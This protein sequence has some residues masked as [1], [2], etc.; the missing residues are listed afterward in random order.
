MARFPALPVRVVTF[1]TQDNLLITGAY[2]P[3]PWPGKAPMA[4]L[5][6]M[7][8]SD[9]HAFDPLV[10]VLHGAGFAVLAIDLRG[11]GESVGPAA[12]RLA[13]RVAERD[14]KLFAEMDRD[15]EAAYAW[16][17]AQPEADPARF[18]LV[19]AS[20][21]CS[22]ALEYAARDRS[23]DA[24]V[25]LT[26]G[27]GY[28]GLDAIAAA[29]KY[30]RRPVLLIASEQEQAACDEL[31]GLLPGATVHVVG[32]AGSDPTSLH[33][34]RMFGRVVGIEAAI[35]AFL[36]TTAGEPAA[37][38]VKASIQGEVYHAADAGSARQINP[39]NLRWFSSA[40]EAQA[41]GLRPPK[42][43][44]SARGQPRSRPASGESFPGH[45]SLP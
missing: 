28:L 23:V 33:G 10:P 6:H 8:G 37:N 30:G 17:A 31:K 25:C 32:S 34:T 4:I 1:P 22:V 15:V 29:R 14:K 44:S 2:T 42:L 3:P 41:R 36:K 39:R 16:L 24:M 38:P 5:L 45:G 35:A 11:H 26:P 40:E 27:T 12:L 18:V 13:R 43:R 9:R 20:V 21:G 19:G 7:Y